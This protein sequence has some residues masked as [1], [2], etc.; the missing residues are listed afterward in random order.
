MLKS[1]VDFECRTTCD[2][3]FLTSKDLLE[4]AKSL[5]AKGVKKYFFQKYR[6]IEA[7]KITTDSDCENIFDDKELIEYCKSNFEQFEIR[8]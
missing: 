4:I 8:R 7:D 1:E 2:P 5:Q 3:R 6:P